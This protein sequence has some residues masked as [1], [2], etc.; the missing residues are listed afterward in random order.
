VLTSVMP[1]DMRLKRKNAFDAGL[2]MG[3]HAFNKATGRDRHLAESS[4]PFIDPATGRLKAELAQ[5]RPCPVCGR[6]WEAPIFVKAGFAHGKCP[7]CGTIYVNP[8]LTDDAVLAHYRQETSWVAVL[9]TET[10]VHFDRLKYQYGLDVLGPHLN[11]RRVLDVGAGTGEFPRLARENDLSVTALELHAANAAHLRADGFEVIDQP[12]EQAGLPSHLFDA[13]TLWEVLEHIVE[14]GPLLDAAAGVLKPDGL[15]LILVPNAD[16]LVSRLLHEKSGTFGGH[17]HVTFF[18]KATIT[19]LLRDHGFE[20][21]DA[22]TLIT[23][24]G[25]INNH[26]NFEDPY[27]GRSDPV[28]DVL[29]PAYIHERFLGSKLLVLARLDHS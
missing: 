25:A 19:R 1:A 3:V 22:E 13:V 5:L 10:Q 17:S 14:P 18:N 9:N 12:L 26:L 24:L 23:E 21:I 20:V 29:T 28:L 8:V 6:S 7:D 16:S 4:V 2:V 11:G 27:L 15:I